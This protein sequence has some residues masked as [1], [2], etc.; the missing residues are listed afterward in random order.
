MVHLFCDSTIIPNV[1]TYIPDG[2]PGGRKPSDH[3]IVYCEPRL[4]AVTKPARGLVVKKTRR[5][6][7]DRMRQL[8][9]WIQQESWESVFDGSG[10]S[11]MAENLTNLVHT[12]LEEICPEEE[13]KISQMEG[14][15]TSL[16]LQ[17]LTRQKMREYTKHGNS[18]RFKQLKKKIKERVKTEGKKAIEKQFENAKGKGTKWI[19]EISRLSARPGED[20]SKTFSI[21][22][23]ID[24]NF[25]AQESAQAICSH[26]AAISQE[27]TPIEE[28]K[29]ARWMEAQKKLS[30]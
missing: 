20:K 9:R 3:P 24:S 16:A 27:Y 30:Q 18:S 6:D 7:D 5:V 14:K 28:D 21:Q 29:S 12:K 26:F 23:H 25:T 4:E 10:S 15:I 19:R 2:H 8:A 1:L 11:G 13:V 17:K 22:N